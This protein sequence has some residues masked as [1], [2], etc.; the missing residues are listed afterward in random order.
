MAGIRRF[1]CTAGHVPS[2]ASDVLVRVWNHTVMCAVIA[3]RLHSGRRNTAHGGTPHTRR[4]TRTTDYG[5]NPRSPRSF[6]PRHDGS[7]SSLPLRNSL[8]VLRPARTGTA[9]LI[10]LGSTIGNGY[11]RK[12]AS[13]HK[14]RLIHKV[15]R[16]RREGGFKWSDGP[17]RTG[18]ND[19][20]GAPPPPDQRSPCCHWPLA[21]TRPHDAAPPE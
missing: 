7:G 20:G 19:T 16:R 12:K 15:K 6:A 4:I 10:R 13:L 14:H 5:P 11:A 21:D 1:P 3:R 17:N 8:P 2:G 9:A 18:G